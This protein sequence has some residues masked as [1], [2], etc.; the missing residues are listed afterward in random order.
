[1]LPLQLRLLGS[2]E[3]RA[4]SGSAAAA[5]GRQ[6]VALLAC[7]ALPDAAQRTRAE[8]AALV[9]SDRGDEQAAAS[10]RVELARLRKAFGP[11]LL[12]NVDLGPATMPALNFEQTDV[13]LQRFRE[14]AA[15]PSRAHEAL[16]LYRGA[17]LEDFPL[18]ERDGFSRWLI[19][20]RA[21]L[22]GEAAAALLR[23]LRGAEA[24][25]PLARRL[26]RLDPLCEEGWRY[27]IR[28]HAA[29]GEPGRA[30]AA[31]EECVRALGRV[32][33]APAMETRALMETVE[34]EL[35]SATVNVFRHAEAQS[36]D[37]SFEWVRKLREEMAPPRATAVLPPMIEDRPSI[38]VLPFRDVSRPGEADPWLARALTE[39]TTNALARMPGFFVS[40]RQSAEVVAARSLDTRAIAAELGVRYLLEA[41]LERE[42][43]SLRSNLRLIDGRSG[44][45]IW[46]DTVEGSVNG[47]M[48]LR[49]AAVREIAGR[50]QPRLLGAEIDR[51]LHRPPENRDAWT[52]TLQAAGQI[53]KTFFG[54]GD[55]ARSDALLEQAIALDPDYAMAH[56]LL[57]VVITWQII[58]RLS[59]GAFG[60]RWKAR[61]H[62]EHALRLEPD[63]S[64]VLSACAETALYGLGDL[65]RSQALL[66][67]ALRR[68]PNDANALA[69]LG[70]VRRQAGESPEAAL[71]LI[72]Q[73][74]R[75][76]PRD[77]RSASWYCSE[78]WCHWKLGAYD[79][80][81][82]A[83]RRSL[84]IYR[85]FGWGWVVL[86]CALGLQ[87][88]WPEARAAGNVVRELMPRFSPFG[89]YVL[90]RLL[91]RNRFI[92]E[93]REGYRRLREVLEQ[94]M[95]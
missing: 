34:A 29:A 54:G 84:E 17:L 49:D 11:G 67:A 68:D 42:G 44:L 86:T 57:S 48:A 37:P 25:E 10:L 32:G 12:R 95:P 40:A 6:S 91:Y 58:G 41:S 30:R 76:S 74:M 35:T 45:H 8:L 4:S 53:Y 50:L 14:A 92:S 55:G 7:L 21:L 59:P 47:S 18:R 89:F 2:F 71:V 36:A 23:L 19:E 72:A 65:D 5:P 43:P 82:Q 24:S 94:A 22:A 46:A 90:A 27:L 26:V 60:R 20:Q 28:T 61:R 62:M 88:R 78:A 83:A 66:E 13:D 75:L 79:R 51:A 56:A 3:A 73:A 1:M 52:L 80:M 33:A 70:H 38:A 77:P 16:M 39:E 93:T 87:E 9:W 63:N 64:F 81:E 85:L 31:F 69:M 15:Q